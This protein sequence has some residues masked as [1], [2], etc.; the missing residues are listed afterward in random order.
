MIIKMSYLQKLER[1]I[2]KQKGENPQAEPKP[3]IDYI[4]QLRL[5]EL[6]KRSLAVEIYSEVLGCSF[7]LCSNELMALQIKE[8]YPNAVTYTVDE[9]R[10]IIR[11]NPTQEDLKRIHNTKSVFPDSRVIEFQLKGEFPE[12]LV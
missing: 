9:M 10:E 12:A 5:S 6:A 11:L 4:S 8:D 3:P 2:A 1:Y 7:W